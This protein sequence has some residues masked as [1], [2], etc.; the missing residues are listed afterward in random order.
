VHSALFNGTDAPLDLFTSE[1]YSHNAYVD[2]QIAG[3]LDIAMYRPGGDEYFGILHG[4]V[5]NA[6]RGSFEGGL[7]IM[8]GCNGLDSQLRSL[9]MLQAFIG[10]GAKVVI[11]W[12]ASVSSYHTDIATEK[13][14]RYLLIE[15]KTVKDAIDATN[16][17]VEPDSLTENELE[18]YPSK[19][20][21]FH[22][23]VDVGNYTIPHGPLKS[24]AAEMGDYYILS[25]GN[26]GILASPLLSIMEPC[27]FGKLRRK[28]F[29]ASQSASKQ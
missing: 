11:G 18:Y 14:L 12:N 17:E 13:L 10:K 15:N 28:T 21:P 9:S 6:M 19:D 20:L 26:E 25:L 29:S 23:T 8:M 7:I 24:G 2:D 22:S 16:N 3:R 5:A 1:R 27:A 4:F